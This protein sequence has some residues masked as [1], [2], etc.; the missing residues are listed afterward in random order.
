MF[1][2]SLHIQ[3]F[4]FHTQINLR[5]RNEKFFTVLRNQNLSEQKEPERDLNEKLMMMKK[6]KMTY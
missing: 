4:T 5:V 2:T 3:T 6:M 1:M